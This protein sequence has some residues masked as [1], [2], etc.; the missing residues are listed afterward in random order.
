MKGKSGA[1]AASQE[2]LRYADIVESS[3]KA[4][5]K[6][7][8]DGLGMIA[9]ENI[10]SPAVRDIVVSDLHGRYAEG[11]PGKRYYQGCD[12]FDTIEALG[13]ELAREVFGASFANIQSISGLS[14]IHI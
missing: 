6:L 14:L 5:G 8:R 13:I 4:S 7:Y 10:V 2:N 1:W 12:D 11:L 3:V 9:S